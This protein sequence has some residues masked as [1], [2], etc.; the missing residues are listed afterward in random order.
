MSGSGQDVLYICRTCPR[1]EPAPRPGE[2]KRGE[3]LAA[4]IKRLMRDWP[5]RDDLLVLVV[6]CLS[7]CPKPCNAA[8]DAPEKTR[9][10]FGQLDA[11]YAPAVLEAAE[12]YLDSADG[13]LP[14]DALPAPLKDRVTA[15]APASLRR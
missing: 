5:R 11:G 8:L 15:R 2:R 3:M 7:G 6:N 9:L 14:D 12:R 4:E 1:Y 10:R 13:N